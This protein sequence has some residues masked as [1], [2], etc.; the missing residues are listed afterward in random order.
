MI[1][2]MIIV[3]AFLRKS[4]PYDLENLAYRKPAWQAITHFNNPELGPEKAVDGL[5]FNRSWFG[6]QCSISANSQTTATWWVDLQAIRS[7]HHIVIYYRTSHGKKICF[8]LKWI[9]NDN[10]L[11]TRFLGFSIFV[12]NT[13]K[14]EDGMLCF[15]D[16]E[17]N[18]TTITDVV[19][20]TCTVHGRYVIYYN[21]RIPSKEYPQDYSRTAYSELCEVEVYGCPIE[22]YY[23]SDCFLP[24]LKN[25]RECDIETG[26]CNQCKAGFQGKKLRITGRCDIRIF[27]SIY[28]C[29]RMCDPGKFGEK[30]KGICGMCIGECYH[31]N[32][33]CSEGCQTGYQGDLCEEDEN[34]SLA[35]RFLGFSIYISDTEKKDDG[36]LCF[37]DNKYNMSTIPAVVNITCQLYGHFVIYYNERIN[38]TVYP[39]GYS[40]YAFN[41]LC[42]VEVYEC[43]HGRYGSECEEF[44]GKCKGECDH[45]NGRCYNGCKPGYKGLS[46]NAKCPS[47]SYGTN[48]TEICGACLGNCN[49]IDG[50]C[51]RGCEAG[52]MRGICKEE[53]SLGRFGVNC[54]SVCGECSGRCNNID[55]V[56]A[57]GCKAGYHGKRCL[58]VCDFGF[59][60]INCQ[61][62]CSMFCSKSRN[63][64]RFSGECIDGCKQGWEGMD[65][66]D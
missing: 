50:H 40:K 45:V 36:T 66:L 14:K 1:F 15:H 26:E 25:C 21:E 63:C 43:P 33:T 10:S 34:N 38:N 2:R 5:K 49:T 17:Y 47:G 13:R 27:H 51:P 31:I 60:G 64:S 52:Y 41:E 22:G 28:S 57:G 7:I 59:Y 16:E 6:Y 19:N 32:G 39:G 58:D 62:Q 18:I 61:H 30:C 46:C 29:C 24:C 42:E 37:H 48:C 53:C 9:N 8:P 55:G 54:S 23:G 65:C 11:T 44:C 56:C 3:F 12:S 35:G 20:I 4:C